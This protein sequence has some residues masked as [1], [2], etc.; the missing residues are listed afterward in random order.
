MNTLA[1]LV[2]E[3]INELEA[4]NQSVEV[5]EVSKVVDSG[6][7]WESDAQRKR[8]PTVNL[9]TGSGA[10]LLNRDEVLRR[11]LPNHARVK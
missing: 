7:R 2:T 3:T 11:S 10:P 4:Q 9:T 8:L 1:K 5:V 6:P